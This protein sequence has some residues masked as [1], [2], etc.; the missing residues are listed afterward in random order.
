MFCVVLFTLV[1]FNFHMVCFVG[2][3]SFDVFVMLCY[4]FNLAHCLILIW[5]TEYSCFF[6]PSSSYFDIYV[7]VCKVWIQFQ[8]VALFFRY[9]YRETPKTVI[10]IIAH[11]TFERV[12]NCDFF[13]HLSNIIYIGL[14]CICFN[15]KMTFMRYIC[16]RTSDRV[17]AQNKS[18]K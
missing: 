5:L 6:L 8:V 13:S 3:V 2:C 18:Y 4:C 14:F 12:L 11:S 10:G 15:L 17:I 1:L 9:T 7:C 16:V